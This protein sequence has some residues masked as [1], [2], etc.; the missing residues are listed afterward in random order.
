MEIAELK[1]KLEEKSELKK[2]LEV[3]YNQLMGQI[4][5]LNELIEIEQKKIEVVKEGK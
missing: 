3:T 5:L 1:G 4:S 2:R